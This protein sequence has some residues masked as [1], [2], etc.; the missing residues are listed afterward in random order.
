MTN[1]MNAHRMRK[2]LAVTM[3]AL[4]MFSG[5]IVMLD[6]SDDSDA[7]STAQ[8]LYG[9][10]SNSVGQQGDG[11][12]T[13]VTTPTQIGSSLGTITDVV[14]STN[15]TFFLTSD[16]KLYGMGDNSS[17]QLGN[18]S[19]STI[20][21]P[22]QIG[23]SLGTITDVVCSTITTFFLTSDGKL[24]GMGSN[25]YY[26]QGNGGLTNV[27]TPTQIGSTLGTI[28]DVV[29]STSTTFFLTSDGK[30]YGMGYNNNGQQG[31]ETTTT[32]TTP[33]QIGSS[34]GTITDVVC[35]NTTTFFLT[36]DGKLYGMGYNNNGQQGNGGT[37][38]VKTPTQIGSTL[39]TITD[40][41]CS[42]DTTFFLTSDGKLYG[43]G[44]NSKGQQGN[45]GT[46]SVKTPTQIGSGLG[47]ILA[48][49]TSGGDSSEQSSG[50]KGGTTKEMVKEEEKEKE[51]EDL[52]KGGVSASSNTTFFITRQTVMDVTISSNNSDYGSVDETSLQVPSGASV[53]IADNVLTIGSTTVTATPT[54][55]TAEYTYAFS[56]WSGVSDGDTI[57]ADTTITANFTRTLNT[58]TVTISVNNNSY[59]SLSQGTVTSVP[60][61]TSISANDN[62]LTVGTTDITATPSANTDNYTYAFDEW[63]GLTENMTVSGNTTITATFDRTVRQYTITWKIDNQTETQLVDYG[64]TPTHA[65]PTKPG[66]EFNGWDPEIETVTEDATYTATWLKLYTATL[67]YNAMGGT[68]TPTAQTYTGT[69]LTDHT[70]TITMD[71][72]TKTNSAFA[73]WG[74]TNSDTEPTYQPGDTIDVAYNGTT[75]LYAVWL[76]P[77]FVLKFNIGGGTNGPSTMY[78]YSESDETHDFTIPDTEPTW[79][80]HEF[81]GW[82]TT[83]NGEVEYDPSDT[84][85][86]DADETVTLYAI[87][88]R[89]GT[90]SA[91]GSM[92][93]ILPLLMIVGLIM[94]LLAVVFYYRM[95]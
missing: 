90:G 13:D 16:G 81:S 80:G 66:Y 77:N 72:P 55:S 3:V 62:V 65:D 88:E 53:T 83:Q 1:S 35:S 30:L 6:G 71:V 75:T 94:G 24:Y 69:D 74:L 70:F 34:L 82:S 57:T 89:T 59:G 56:S 91:I 15:T 23:S 92:I 4:M 42:G 63:T 85:T 79:W 22:T 87:Y 29:C 84:I 46:G 33:T 86:V 43:M 68:G 32:V 10:G 67:Q 48:I 41:I 60:Y 19:G 51:P 61:G 37:G 28:T 12:T 64:A 20:G 17:G 14:C 36:S 39:G 58:Y 78:Y 31:D 38:S 50:T 73:G 44:A 11:T 25:S 47:E 8:V 40:V 76:E 5:M 52:T 26:Q 18:V 93:D 27:T 7:S 54:T 21:T 95:R 45:G 9:M 49:A 2:V